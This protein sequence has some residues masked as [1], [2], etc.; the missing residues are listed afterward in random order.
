MGDYEKLRKAVKRKGCTLENFEQVDKCIDEIISNENDNDK[1][2]KSLICQFEGNLNQANHYSLIA[3]FY[4][5]IIGGLSVQSN[6]I[7]SFIDPNEYANANANISLSMFKILFCLF[8]ILGLGINYLALKTYARDYKNT[9]ILKVL[10]FKLDELNIKREN[11]AET[12]KAE[13]RSIENKAN[14]ASEA[15]ETKNYREYVVRVY[16]K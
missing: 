12:D 8:A 15:V 2:I 7:S 13:E 1:I 6:M 11:G 5:V 16:D 14:T 3:V 9:F 10:Y 4:A